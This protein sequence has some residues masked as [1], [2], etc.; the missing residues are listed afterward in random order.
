MVATRDETPYQELDPP[1]VKLCWTLNWLGVRTLGSCGGHD[2]GGELPAHEW[3]VTFACD[4]GRDNRPLRSAW[5]AAEFIAWAVRDLA[6]ANLAIRLD[7]W[8]PPPWLNEP[9][10]ALRFE[11]SGRRG[12]RGGIEPDDVAEHIERTFDDVTSATPEEGE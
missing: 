3:R 10:R 2:E 5:L 9:A 4:I 8:A 1:V 6:R 12:P 11:I 7:A